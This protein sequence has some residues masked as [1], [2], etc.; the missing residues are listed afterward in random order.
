LALRLQPGPIASAL[1]LI[2]L[3]AGLPCSQ[4]LLR[5]GGGALARQLAAALREHPAELALQ[6]AG[7]H[8]LLPLSGCVACRAPLSREQQDAVGAAGAVPAAAAALATLA[9]AAAAAES[10]EARQLASAALA[11]GLA[12][13]QHL[14]ADHAAN[15]EQLA[16][17]GGVPT[18]RSA[19]A[20]AT[21]AHP[22]QEPALLLLAQL[23]CRQAASP[24]E[25]QAAALA[26][27]QAAQ[28]QAERG[29]LQAARAAAWAMAR[30]LRALGGASSATADPASAQLAAELQL[31]GVA[32]V[33]AFLQGCNDKVGAGSVR[34]WGVSL[35]FVGEVRF[36]PHPP[37]P[38]ALVPGASQPPQLCTEPCATPRLTALR[39]PPR[40]L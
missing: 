11:A 33:L 19:L 39:S 7:M 27:W 30:V 13:L 18:V 14:C 24:E 2:V 37:P 16:G 5:L 1:A 21:D 26:V 17:A 8:L 12:A 35:L 9:A 20:A 36:A 22:A 32:V 4:E 6:A 29:R 40:L 10:D 34:A 28:A 15:L 23:A 25:R 31:R 3:A 38:P